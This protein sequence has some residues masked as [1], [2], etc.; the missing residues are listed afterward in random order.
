MADDSTSRSMRLQRRR[1]ERGLPPVG[2]AEVRALQRHMYARLHIECLNAAAALRHWGTAQ[3][4]TGK[5]SHGRLIA[6][7]KSY[8][9][10]W[11]GKGGRLP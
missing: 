1:Q 7:A 3:T 4:K 9:L 2:L 6:Q 5:A 10:Q 11:R 8:R